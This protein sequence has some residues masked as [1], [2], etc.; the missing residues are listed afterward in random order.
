MAD[1]NNPSNT[2]SSDTAASTAYVPPSLCTG[3]WKLQA[4]TDCGAQDA[5]YAEQIAAEALEIAGVGVNVF[6][7]LGVHEQGRLVD[8]TGAG[9]A[10]SSGTASGSNIA[11][12]FDM[13]VGTV[14]KSSFTG[15]DVVSKPAWLGYYFGFKQSTPG[16]SRYGAPQHIVQHITTMRIQQSPIATRRASQIRVERSDGKIIIGTPQFVG[17][18]DGSIQNIRTGYYSLPGTLILEATS[19]TTFLVS[20]SETGNLGTAIVGSNFSNQHI[21]FSIQAGSIPFSVGDMFIIG[22]DIR[23]L[24]VD[25]VNLPNTGN[26]ETISVKHSVPSPYWRI[27]PLFFS[28]EASNEPW[29]IETLQLMDYE[30]TSLDNIQDLFFQ[31]NRDRDYASCSNLLRAQYQP[32]DSIGDLGKFGFSILD[33]YVF[34]V[35][36]AKMVEALGR[37]IVVGDILELPSEMQYDHNLKPVRKYLEVTDTG[38]S[39][40]G[41][42]PGWK[43]ILFRFQAVPLIP[44]QEHRDIVGTINTN[45]Y[46]ASDDDFFNGI[47]KPIATENLIASDAN[48]AQAKDDTPEE[49][50]DPMDIASNKAY[51]GPTTK[52]DNWDLYIEDGLPKDGLP[53]GEGY[54]LPD[55]STATDGD[56]FR[57]N[58]PQSTNIP[59]RLYQFNSVK[60]KWVYV[61]TDRRMEKSSFKK[62]V[63]KIISSGGTS[64]KV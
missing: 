37:P 40:E 61:E 4:D 27:V 59:A 64:I 46:S 24:R 32:M 31:E 58:Y 62:S 33:Q 22:L 60:G 55:V 44:G 51:L 30:A 18:G 54:Q 42:T 43:P 11:S 21:Q 15:T 29:E 34:T 52:A 14:W 10:I 25:V 12:A 9:H 57:L 26:L 53:Y 28:G 49:G 23:W 6:K 5:K 50:T 63:K 16:V 45:L 38:W 19:P 17:L 36:F 41:F 13:S 48:A 3:T 20:H 39:S 7:L 8:L 35:S 2:S 47:N 1:C 56:Y